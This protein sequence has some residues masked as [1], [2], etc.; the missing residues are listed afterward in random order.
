MATT[1]Q[2]HKRPKAETVNEPFEFKHD[3]EVY[4]L[5]PASAIKAGMLRRFRKLDDLDIAF[6]LIEELAEPDALAALDDMPLEEFN[7]TLSDWQE[8]IGATPGK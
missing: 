3:G 1:P 2:D 5:P 4:T 6:S 7:Q 8:S